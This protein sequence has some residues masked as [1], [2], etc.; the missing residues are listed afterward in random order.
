MESHLPSSLEVGIGGRNPAQ[1]I[2][3]KEA[4]LL[5]V[6]TKRNTLVSLQLDTHTGPCL[7]QA[8]TDTH[9]RTWDHLQTL[10]ASLERTPNILPGLAVTKLGP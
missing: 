10:T 8:L 1:E 9:L 3:A 7:L 5:P 4:E 6:G 2:R